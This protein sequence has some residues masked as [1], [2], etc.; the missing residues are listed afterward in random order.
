MSCIFP[1]FFQSGFRLSAIE[2][3]YLQIPVRI[4]MGPGPANPHPRVTQAQAA[5]LLGHMHPPF[6]KIMDGERLPVL[7]LTV[8]G[9]CCLPFKSDS[10]N[11][12]RLFSLWT[13]TWA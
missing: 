13:G 10:W 1:V 12:K 8:G 11:W 5:P 4:L 9:A 7:L 3:Y 6:F 2:Q